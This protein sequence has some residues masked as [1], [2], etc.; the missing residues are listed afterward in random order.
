[1][2]NENI[3]IRENENQVTNFADAMTRSE[4]QRIYDRQMKMLREDGHHH[5][6]EFQRARSQACRLFSAEERD[7]RAKIHRL[8]MQ[9]IAARERKHNLIQDARDM[10]ESRVNVNHDRR[11]ELRMEYDLRMAELAMG[12]TLNAKEGGMVCVGQ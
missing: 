8:E 6:R 4:V 2:T 3:E 11:D 7:I 9:L 10:Y 1:M 12:V 5:W